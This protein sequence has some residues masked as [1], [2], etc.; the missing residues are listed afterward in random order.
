MVPQYLVTIFEAMGLE[1]ENLSPELV[2]GSDGLG[3]DSQ[4]VIEL[5]GRLEKSLQITLPLNS[6]KRTMSLAAVTQLIESQ[7]LAR[8]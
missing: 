2:L 4:E 5:Y 1:T 7:L 8:V 6:L 3:M